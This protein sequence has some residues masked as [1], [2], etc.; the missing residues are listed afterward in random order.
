MTAQSACAPTALT[1]NTFTRPCYSFAGWN[2]D[3]GGS[4]TAYA[5]GATYGFGADV[6]LYA[7][8]T[9]TSH[10]V[11]FDSNGGSGSMSPQTACAP[12]ALTSNTFTR[13]CYSFAGWNTLANGTGT[14]Y[15]DSATY[16]FS[17]DVTLYAQWAIDTYTITVT[18]S[19]HGTISPDPA[20]V[21][22]GA[23][24]TFTIEPDAYYRVA[25]LTVDGSP[26][27]P[28]E[29][30]TFNNVREAGHTINATFARVVRFNINGSIG[31]WNVSDSGVLLENINQSSLTEDVYV[32]ISAETTML[33]GGQPINEFNVS[34]VASPPDAPG[35][36]HVLA[37]F[38][39]EPDGAVFDP[40]IEITI[41]FN[42]ST[43][44]AGEEVRIAFYNES[45]P[46][47]EYITGTVNNLEGDMAAATFTV[48]HF[49]TYGVLTVPPAP[50]HR[51]GGYYY[52][53]MPTPEPTA[54]PTSTPAAT[55]TS[56]PAPTASPE[57]TATPAPTSTPEEEGQMKVHE[58]TPTP[59]PAAPA[60]PTFGSGSHDSNDWFWLLLIIVWSLVVLLG[61]ALILRILL[62]YTHQ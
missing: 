41:V 45:T 28:A 39:F 52:P 27:T 23:S 61:L 16:D 25:T 24:K 20:T 46:A 54:A 10:T 21:A 19:A 62:R 22:C 29:S 7:Q 43:V 11:T 26:V 13:T 58:S 38:D 35:S 59:T 3:A 56:S 60:A 15:A 55:P 30:Y 34:V 53:P 31:T 1:T 32:N 8:W 47:W 2:T 18:Q 40:G 12:T 14:P 51:P 37:A 17:A 6:T 50:T 9:S 5:D 49:T 33:V 42:R 4:G 48:T 57:P 36:G 44:A